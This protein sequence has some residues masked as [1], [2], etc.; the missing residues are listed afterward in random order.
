MR[1]LAEPLLIDDADLPE[2]AGEPAQLLYPRPQVVAPEILG[3]RRVA[4]AI[5]GKALEQALEVLERA[6]LGPSAIAEVP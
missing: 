2:V 1:P 4:L 6:D 3:E 5:V